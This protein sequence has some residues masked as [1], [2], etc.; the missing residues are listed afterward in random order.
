M[1]ISDYIPNVFAASNPMYEG[2]LGS[3]DAAALSQRSN[4]AG[5]LGA[6][7][8]LA[9]PGDHPPYPMVNSSCQPSCVPV[10]GVSPSGKVGTSFGS[11]TRS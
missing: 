10:S 2:L 6:A 9:Q 3:E 5:L 11:S 1:A 7:V 4:V 8:A